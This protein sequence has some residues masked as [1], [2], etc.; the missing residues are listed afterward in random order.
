MKTSHKSDD[1]KKFKKKGGVNK[2]GT[3]VIYPD[4]FQNLSFHCSLCELESFPSKIF[5]FIE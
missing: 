5:F 3:Y 1:L 2:S 4:L